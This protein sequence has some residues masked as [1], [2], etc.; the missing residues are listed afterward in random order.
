MK[1]KAK[2]IPFS[3]KPKQE[4]KTKMLIDVLKKLF[5]LFLKLNVNTFR[6]NVALTKT[7][8]LVTR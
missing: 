7:V 3:P 4:T 2:D 8:S 5:K 6:D 1:K